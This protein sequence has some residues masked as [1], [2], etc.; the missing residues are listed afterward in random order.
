MNLVDNF[1]N[2]GKEVLVNGNVMA[3]FSA[4]GVKNLDDAVV[5]GESLGVHG[6]AMDKEVLSGDIYTLAGQKTKS[7]TQRGL[8]IVGGKKVLVK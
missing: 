6:V 1:D 3:Y 2:L 7:M 8:Y 4:P 5:D